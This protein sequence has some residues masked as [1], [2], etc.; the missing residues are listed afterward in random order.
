M[1][2]STHEHDERHRHQH[3]EAGEPERREQE[4]QHLFGAVGRGRDAVARQHAERRLLAQ[5]LLVQ[6]RGDQRLA[7]HGALDP[8]A[9]PLGD[10]YRDLFGHRTPAWVDRAGRQWCSRR[11]V[12]T[13]LARAGA[14]RSRS[15]RVSDQA[16]TRTVSHHVAPTSATARPRFSS[17]TAPSQHRTRARGVGIHD[18]LTRPSRYRCERPLSG[19]GGRASWTC[20]DT[21]PPAHLP[22]V[23]RPA[24][25]R[26]SPC[27]TRDA[28]GA[29]AAPMSSSASSRRTAGP[30]PPSASATCRSS[31]ASTVTYRGAD[32]RGDGP[33]R[34]LAPPARARPRRRARAHQR[35]RVRAA[36]EAL[37]GRRHAA[38]RGHRRDEHR[39]RPAPR[40]AQRRRR[41]RSPACRSAR[42]CRTRWCARPSRSQLVDMT[43]EALR[44][45]MAHGNIYPPREGRRRA[46]QLLPR[47]ATSPRCASSPCSGWPTG[48]RR[49]CSATASSTA[50][51][52]PGRPA[53][54]SSSR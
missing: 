36:R 17:S 28:A 21:R 33:R 34:V 45:R 52:A 31:R 32:V 48:S 19:R 15:G 8:V 6:L 42:P 10:V 16:S 3:V 24:S 35:P 47:R 14:G 43:P 5:P 39:E 49:A 1:R 54:A 44:R 38:R 13:A 41:R 12:G 46:G 4:D 20:D 9:D 27:S 29:S 37:A 26:P 51:P 23:P 53:S 40:V 25:A 18:L 7:E 30:A 2:T 11:L 22:R 50:S